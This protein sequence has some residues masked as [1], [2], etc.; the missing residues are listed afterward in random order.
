[1]Q[2]ASESCPR[3]STI[4][5]SITAGDSP[6]MPFCSTSLQPDLAVNAQAAPPEPSPRASSFSHHDRSSSK[7]WKTP[8]TLSASGLP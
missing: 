2:I 5:A 1:P 6:I 4:R 8:A 7:S 3:N